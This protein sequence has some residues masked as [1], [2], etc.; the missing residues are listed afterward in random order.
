VGQPCPRMVR[1]RPCRS[2]KPPATRGR[3]SSLGCAAR[4]R[5]IAAARLQQESVSRRLAGT[6]NTDEGPRDNTG[7]APALRVRDSRN[8]DCLRMVDDTRG[9]GRTSQPAAGLRRR[10]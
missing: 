9:R 8:S 1:M 7:H 3:V 2:G 4:R 5:L 6:T 10:L